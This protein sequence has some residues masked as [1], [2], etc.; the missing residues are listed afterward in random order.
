MR[1]IVL[2]LLVVGYLVGLY[3][4]VKRDDNRLTDQA[5]RDLDQRTRREQERRRNIV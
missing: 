1:G 5:L 4:L 3:Q 2:G